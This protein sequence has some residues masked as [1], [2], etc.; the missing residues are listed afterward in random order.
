[1][2]DLPRL[3]I[4]TLNCA[5]ICNDDTRR[6]LYYFLRTECPADIICLQE[7]R[8]PVRAADFWTQV[9]AGPA[10]WSY[11]VGFLLHPSHT[12]LSHTFSHEGRL[13]CAE[14]TV[15]GSTF[16]V[17]NL[18]APA[19]HARRRNLF[20]S[21]DS[22][23]FD[24]F[25]FAFVAGDWNCCPDPSQ[26]RSSLSDHTRNDHW[27]LL[28]PSLTSFFDGALAGAT[29]PYHT[30]F[31]TSINCSARLDHV[32]VS[33][34]LASCNLSTDVKY[35]PYSD[36]KAVCLTVTPPSFTRPLIWRLNTS[37]LPRADLWAS[38][39][40]VLSG[41]TVSS[42]DAGKVLA[43]SS[44][45]DVAVVASKERRKE[46][47]R[48]QR[49]LRQAEQSARYRRCDLRSDAAT[50]AART[51][52]R[53]HT[54]SGA[55]RAILRGRV[56]W[57][58]EGERCSAFFFSRFRKPNATSRLQQVRNSDGSSFVSDDARHAHIRS[59]YRHL[60]AAPVFDQ[61]ACHS[62]LSPLTL[63]TLTADDIDALWAPITADELAA[64]VRQLPLRKSPGPDGLPYEWYRTYL[65]FMTPLL[66]EL[67]N[68]I[69]TGDDPPASWFTTTLTLLPKP[70]RDHTQM[71]NWRPIT[72]A[73]CD[74][75]IFSKLLAN[76]LATVLPRLLNP[77]QAGFVKGRS[78]PDVA[79]HLKTVLAHAATH[80]VD[81]ALV[82]LDQE[83]AYDRV[84]HDYLFAVLQEFGFPSALARV[85]FNTSGPSHSFILDDG[86]PLP[87]VP[88]SCGVRQGDPLAPLLFNLAL[89]PLLTALRLRLQ[90][91]TLA[92]GCFIV[93]AFADDLTLGLAQTDVPELQRVLAQYGRA[94]N[95]Q[96][97]FDKSKILDLSGN[98]NTPQWIQDTGFTVHD[99]TLPITVLGYDLLR[100][101]AG[102]SEDWPALL[103]D[104]QAVANRLCTRSCALQGRALLV[105][106]MVLSKLW[107]KCRLS[108]PSG[109]LL[110]RVR[111]LAWEAVWAGS[112]ALKPSYKV[113]KRPPRLGGVS[114]LDPEVQVTALQAMW[115]ARFLTA[116]PRPS[117]Y[118]ALAWAFSSFNGGATALATFK[119]LGSAQFPECWQPYVAAW[120]K[121]QPHWSL[122]ISNWTPQEA[123]CF[124]VPLSISA[125]HP[126]GLRL[127]DLV[128]WNASTSEVSLC[129]PDDITD[130]DFGAPS[131]TKKALAALQDGSSAVPA[132]V[133]AL[134]LSD[135]LAPP[136]RSSRRH[137]HA[138]IQVAGVLLF[139]LTTALARRFLDR[140][141]GIFRP[142]DW[143]S[144]GITKL[145]R[146]PKDIWQR[147]HHRSH[148]PRQKETLY[149]FLFNA[150]PLG[151][152]VRHFR[153]APAERAWCHFCP[154]QL[155]DM[156]HFIWTCPLAQ[157]LWREFRDLYS[158]PRAVTLQEAAFS[159]SPHTQV[160]GR[161]YGYRLQAGHA[162]AVH[163]LWLVHT[164]A[165]YD[166]CPASFPAV[167]A[168]FRASLRQ[169]LETLRAAASSEH[170]LHFLEDWSPPLSHSFS[171]T[172]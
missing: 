131:R 67:Y 107:Y 44:A 52:L 35:C 97:N 124:P 159:W 137:L 21:F 29:E 91:V 145:G 3:T 118:K 167:K 63:T 117:W 164:R 58:E 55:T 46:S 99:H 125:R 169:H 154:G 56:R 95:G 172:L 80:A 158:L 150:L 76:R 156:R 25:R 69:L 130:G 1:M 62:F 140:K 112:T 66:L 59:F 6:A 152:R 12:L 93:A 166:D 27:P 33:S 142:L 75:K 134:A 155:Q 161:R 105:N 19:D 102:V 43:R 127:V 64:V 82:F 65:P 38:T 11:H 13:V 37:L 119:G 170:R 20:L 132:P 104:M 143:R 114:F 139:S 23:T 5:G 28:A 144:R 70:N 53:D 160:L 79:L 22:D 100:S 10:V 163:T 128:S 47:L 83:K 148:T 108:S 50:V 85:F 31:H 123:L 18:Y 149:K 92:W 4:C 77:D 101:P 57:L 110:A 129:S 45:R 171:L 121:L 98:T 40:R 111:T 73:N 147:L 17:A 116:H 9:W 60:Y 24:P 103:D 136:A 15:R 16:S 78:A 122:D 133:L 8:T 39:E 115:M 72:L 81:G 157:C 135:T 109:P 71:R 87:A 113:G 120:R 7:P 84:S 14:V 36:H 49:L 94:S 162:V 138:H 34:Q 68:G 96:I 86:Q 51:A 30:F 88:I 74:A 42:W 89:E 126:T 168:L 153:D 141:K 32:F 26:D 61:P 90:G 146:P 48:L 41:T 2:I 151:T 165:V 106:S 54:D